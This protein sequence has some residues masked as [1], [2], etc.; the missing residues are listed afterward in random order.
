MRSGESSVPLQVTRNRFLRISVACLVLVS[1]GIA[2]VALTNRM[3]IWTSSD[4]YCGSACHSMTWANAAYQKSPHYT[5]PVGVRASCGSCHIP[6]DAGHAT[7]LD[8]VRLLWFKSDRGIKDTWHEV[9]RSMATK[10]EWE[11]RRPALRATFES[12][13]TKHN[14]ITC[15]GC[16]SL[17]SFAGPRSQMKLVIHRGLA[18][19]NHY[20]CLGCHSDIGHVYEDL[21]S[22]PASMT[23]GWFTVEQADAGKELF[24]RSCSPCHGAQLEGIAGTPGLR[25]ASWQQRFAGAKLLTVWGE[26]KGPMAQYANVTLSTQQSLDILAFLLQQNGLPAGSQPLANTRQ[27]SATLPQN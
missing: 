23:S 1:I 9:T 3:V 10:E 17:E 25:G 5:N 24:E 19:Q 16:H 27:L 6:Y 14:Y 2:I 8:Y 21:R 18:T 20:D 7:A 22:R 26:I 11:N 13:L 12:Y 15:R 4:A